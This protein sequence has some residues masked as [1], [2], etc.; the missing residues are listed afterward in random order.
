[1]SDLQA[2]EL[3]CRG[4][5]LVLG[6]NWRV[7][8]ILKDFFFKRLGLIAEAGLKLLLTPL[9]KSWAWRNAPH[10]TKENYSNVT[11]IMVTYGAVRGG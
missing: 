7:T 3:R 2:T 9:L 4:L 8:A 6:S 1:M 11:F 5:C 10:T